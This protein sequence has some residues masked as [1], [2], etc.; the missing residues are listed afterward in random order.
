MRSSS[1]QIS[2]LSSEAWGQ[3]THIIVK[4][5]KWEGAASL[6]V[7]HNLSVELKKAS[8]INMLK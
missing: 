2:T 3:A 1:S 4:R 7:I 8:V 6:P 5:Y